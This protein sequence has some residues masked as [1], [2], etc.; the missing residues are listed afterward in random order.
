VIDIADSRLDRIP[1]PD[2]STLGFEVEDF[3]VQLR[4]L[5][6]RCRRLEDKR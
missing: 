1:I 3:R 2:T 4:G 6:R 5:C